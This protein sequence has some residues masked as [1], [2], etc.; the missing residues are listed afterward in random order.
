MFIENI[1]TRAATQLLLSLFCLLAP[2]QAS[3]DDLTLVQKDEEKTITAHS[4]C[5]VIK[6]D[7]TSAIMAPHRSSAEWAVGGNAFLLNT[8]DMDH[9]SVSECGKPAELVPDAAP[10][11]YVRNT[12]IFPNTVK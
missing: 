7:G 2:Y 12:S 6:N 9:V 10:F 4:E 8:A 3:A 1:K 11:A 5:R